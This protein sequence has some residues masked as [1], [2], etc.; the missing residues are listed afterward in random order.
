[1][2]RGEEREEGI[3]LAR[4]WAVGAVDDSAVLE[5]L[6]SVSGISRLDS[7][8]VKKV[9]SAIES[10]TYLQLQPHLIYNGNHND[11]RIRSIVHFQRDRTHKMLKHTDRAF[12]QALSLAQ[13]KKD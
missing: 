8:P 3:G 6:L 2:G 4:K 12:P 11:R 7:L 9:Y 5:T 10:S 1:M 13:S